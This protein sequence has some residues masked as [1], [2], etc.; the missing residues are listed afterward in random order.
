MWGRV[1]NQTQVASFLD[2]LIPLS[3]PLLPRP[4][5]VLEYTPYVRQMVAAD[6]A[7]KA[8]ASERETRSHHGRQTRNRWQLGDYPRYITLSQGGLAAARETLLH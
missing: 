5:A 1:A 3:G 4:A 7:M 8:E 6:D 2:D